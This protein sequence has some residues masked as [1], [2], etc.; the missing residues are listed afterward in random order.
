MLALLLPGDVCDAFA[1][2]LGPADH[3][4]STLTPVRYAEIA[5]TEFERLASSSAQMLRQIRCKQLILHSI[6]REWI[7]N[8]G[9]RAAPERIAH[10]FCEI[11]ARLEKIG[12]VHEDAFEFPLTQADIADAT[13]LTPVHVNRTLKTLRELDLIEMRIKRLHIVN[14]AG[15]CEAALFDPTYLHL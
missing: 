12:L 5:R 14:R 4:M 1:Y 8:I 15:L 11:F 3:S 9:Q 7:A 13:G 2:L 6:E 10:L